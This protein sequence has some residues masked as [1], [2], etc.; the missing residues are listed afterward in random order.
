M[1]TDTGFQHYFTTFRRTLPR[2]VVITPFYLWK[3]SKSTRSSIK[4]ALEPV[5]TR[6]STDMES[7]TSLTNGNH[8]D[9]PPATDGPP[10]PPV[11]NFDPD[12]FRTYLLSLLPPVIGAKPSD[13]HSLFDEEFEER[14]SRFAADTGGVIYVVQVKEES[15][16]V[17]IC[18]LSFS[19]T[20]TRM[21]RRLESDIRLSVDPA[22]YIPSI[23]RNHTRAN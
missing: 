21:F 16:G 11:S 12:I 15:E 22:S 14:V 4:S 10:P 8:H 3:R 20:P 7:Q 18:L 23:A 2:P 13:L 5:S 17:L 19:M 9:S 1:A 6:V